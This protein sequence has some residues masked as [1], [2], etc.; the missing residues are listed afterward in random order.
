MS[1]KNLFKEAIADAKAV[2]EAALANAKAAL[3]EAL[4][5][6]LQ[7]MLAAK[8][9]EMESYEEEELEETKESDKKEKMEEVDISSDGYS[10]DDQWHTKAHERSQAGAIG[11]GEELEE[12]F[13]LSEILAELNEAEEKEEEEEETE[14]TEEEEKEEEVEV[15]DMTIEDLKDLIKDIVSQEMGDEAPEMGAE[16]PMEMG[17]EEEMPAGGDEEE[18][19]LDELLAELDAMDDDEKTKQVNELFGFGK[20]KPEASPKSDSKPECPPGQAKWRDG[21][22]YPVEQAGFNDLGDIPRLENGVI[23]IPNEVWSMEEGKKPLSKKE[24]EEKKEMKEAIDPEILNSIGGVAALFGSAFGIVK[25]MLSSAKKEIAAKFKEKG[26][27]VPSDKELEKLAAVA[28][29]GG[30]DK[31][32]GGASFSQ[33]TT[34]KGGGLGQNVD[35]ELSEAIQTINTLRSELNEVNLLNAKLLYVNKIFKA[36]NLTESQKVKV[37]ASFDKATNVKEAK[38]VFESLQ[39]ALTAAPKKQIKES[40]GFASKA[41][42]VAPNKTIVESNDVISRMQKLANIK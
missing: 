41:A 16:E 7:S 34:G 22:C 19:N 35:E 37:I 6:K 9:N 1:N 21:R 5:P 11:E 40:L 30:L 17:G 28:L 32:T 10:K 8:L 15:K 12:D 14:E 3:E 2:R 42:G 4:T 24:K 13:D 33:S 38:V 20:K 31:A 29:K 39:S 23:L 25:L 18:I 26:E 27:P 36:K